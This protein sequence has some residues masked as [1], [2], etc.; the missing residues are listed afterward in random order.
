MSDAIPQRRW[1]YTKD[2]VPGATKTG[3]TADGFTNRTPSGPHTGYV[4]EEF[5][6]AFQ[7]TGETVSFKS[8]WLGEIPAG[9]VIRVE[10]DIDRVYKVIGGECEA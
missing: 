5:G 3:T 2:P 7:P 10:Q 8:Y 1:V 9:A 4:L 6:S